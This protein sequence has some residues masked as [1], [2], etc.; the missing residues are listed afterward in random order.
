MTRYFSRFLFFVFFVF[1]INGCEG[2]SS[3]TEERQ[4]KDTNPPVILLE[5]H[6]DIFENQRLELFAQA[7]DENS[8]TF[9]WSDSQ[10]KKLSEGTV[11]TINAPHELE[12]KLYVLTATDSEGNS[13]TKSIKVTVHDSHYST[14]EQGIQVFVEDL[15][16]DRY[17]L[18]PLT[19]ADFNALSEENKWKVADK[20]LASMFFGYPLPELKKRLESNTFISDIQNQIRSFTNDM[21]KIEHDIHNPENFYQAT[22]TPIITSRFHAM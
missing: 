1:L 17:K 15:P 2:S 10:K 9:F 13:A 16:V 4:E 14:L 11:L 18:L 3:L 20:L 6:K 22:P 8:I 12:T 5:E 21:G 7:E 19:D